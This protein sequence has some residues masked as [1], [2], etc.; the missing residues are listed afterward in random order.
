[1]RLL[2]RLS[3]ADQL[4]CGLLAAGRYEN[5]VVAR[6]L[7]WDAA[8]VVARGRKLRRVEGRP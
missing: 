6:T 4:A 3:P 1:M 7:G 5:P 2:V 8:S